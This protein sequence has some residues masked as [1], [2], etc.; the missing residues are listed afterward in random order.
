MQRQQLELL[1]TQDMRVLTVDVSQ[2]IEV[3]LVYEECECPKL[4]RLHGQESPKALH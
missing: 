4:S 2:Q 1:S 3:C